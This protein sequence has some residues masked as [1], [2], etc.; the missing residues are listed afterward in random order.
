M[1]Y[2]CSVIRNGFIR[3]IQFSPNPRTGC[4]LII[5]TLIMLISSLMFSPYLLPLFIN[6]FLNYLYGCAESWN[7]NLNTLIKNRTMVLDML[8]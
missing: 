7:F 1:V 2:L 8:I 4:G 5:I 6:I 3:V